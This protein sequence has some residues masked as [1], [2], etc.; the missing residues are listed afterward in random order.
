MKLNRL[1]KYVMRTYVIGWMS[2]GM[3]ILLIDTHVIPFSSPLGVILFAVGGYSPTIAALSV[4]EKRNPKSIATFIF[5]GNHKAVPY[6]FL[7]CLLLA[8][9]Y[10]L[11]S[12][13]F[14]PNMALY[15]FP[16]YWLEMMFVGGFEELGWR[17]VM[18][19]TLEKSMPFPLS[20]LLTG[21]TWAVWH[22]PLW[23]VAGSSQAAFPFL[24]FAA[25]C[26]V[27]S[28]AL[29]AIRKKTKSVIYCCIFHAFSDALLAYIVISINWVPFLVGSAAIIVVSLVI[30]YGDRRKTAQKTRETDFVVS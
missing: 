14:Q 29:A 18:Q 19:P 11:T 21:I 5:H 2:W 9:T 17:G 22:V 7:F 3:L 13:Q 8:S 26:V 16:V 12:R 1:A 15:L 20:V 30:W 24:A 10:Y 27:L 28:F 23:F 25:S 6:V 4:L